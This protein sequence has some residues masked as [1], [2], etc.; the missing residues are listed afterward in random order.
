MDPPTAADATA[1]RA[2]AGG[3][4]EASGVA[5]VP[6]SNHLL[7]VDDGRSRE[8]FSMELTREGIQAGD[9]VTIP[10]GADVMDLEGITTDGR[11]FYVVG[12]QSKQTGFEGDG[13]VRFTFDPKSRRVDDVERIRGLKAWLATNVPELR[14]AEQRV[15]DDVLNVEGL[16]WDPGGSRLLLGLRAPQVDG[17]ALVVPIKLADPGA[18]FSRENLRVDGPT[19]RVRINGAGIRSLEYDA[20]RGAFMVIAGASPDDE[21]EDFRVLEWNGESGSSPRHIVTFPRRVKPEGFTRAVLDGRP[22][23]VIVFD[24]GLYAV[25]P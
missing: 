10:L 25:M 5:H 17:E 11:H 13:L 20:S 16:A 2:I 8:I 3:R 19:I 15:G 12:S 22:V 4:F 23:G 6:E 18:S 1:P 24:A 21:S 9:A 7:F 14:G